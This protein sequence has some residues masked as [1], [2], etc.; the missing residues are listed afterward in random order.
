MLILSGMALIIGAL[1]AVVAW[2]LVW[3]IAVITNFSFYRSWSSVFQSPTH[4][5]LGYSMLL[6]PVIGGLII[7]WL[8][9]TGGTELAFAVAGTAGLAMAVSG[10]VALRRSRPVPIADESAEPGEELAAA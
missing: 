2:V 3:L 7:G 5:H 9:A 1:S 4:H 10:A 6:V 8:S